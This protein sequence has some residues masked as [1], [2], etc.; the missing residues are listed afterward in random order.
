[1]HFFNEDMAGREVLLYVNREVIEAIGREGGAGLQD[2]IK[3]VKAGPNYA[4]PGNVCEK[5]FGLFKM[6]RTVAK[7]YPLYIAYLVLFV[8]AATIDGGFD[9]KAYYPR[10]CKALGE[11]IATGSYPGFERMARLWENLERWSKEERAEELGRFT[12]R[13]RGGW[14]HVGIPLSQLILSEEER[15]HLP[16]VFYEAAIDPT[17]PPADLVLRN[18]LLDY[19]EKLLR[20]RTRKLLA[21]EGTDNSELLAALLDFVLEEL[22]NWDCTM[23]GNGSDITVTKGPTLAPKKTV[24]G[25]RICIDKIDTLLGTAECRLRIKTNRQIPEDGLFL[26]YEG[27][28]Y[29]CKE[30]NEPSW[31]TRL[32]ESGTD[33]SAP[34]EASRLDWING[35]TFEDHENNWAAKLSGKPVRLFMQRPLES[36]KGWIECNQLAY[37]SEFIVACHKDCVSK[38]EAWGETCGEL[39][40]MNVSGLPTAWTLLK[41]I[42][43]TES[44]P[45][46]DVLTLPKQFHLYLQGGVKTGRGNEYL[47]FAPPTI[48]ITGGAGEEGVAVNGQVLDPAEAGVWRLPHE[49]HSNTTF[50]IQIFNRESKDVLERR[51][52]RLSEPSI[53]AELETSLALDKFGD[54]VPE[55]DTRDE[56][57]YVS[58]AVVYGTYQEEPYVMEEPL[59]FYLSHRIVFIGPQPGQVIDWPTQDPTVEWK[60]VWA[61]ASVGR[62]RWAVNYCGPEG[63]DAPPVTLNTLYKAKAFRRWKEAVWVNRRRNIKP[64]IKKLVSLWNVYVGVAKHV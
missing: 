9:D 41:G 10:L 11:Q 35:A 19:G 23:P 28:T 63:G 38:V 14:V 37:N 16:Q 61:L 57:S 43:A 1:V 5:A 13:R 6:P 25:M 49:G 22:T 2:F 48:V 7:E 21:A 15:E 52:I 4:W 20:R 34:C 31:T 32:W 50:E 47:H 36:I 42:D 33:S 30:A 24:V 18:I 56:A 60:P 62:N 17:D 29:I 55:G 8:Y 45:G 46:V 58:G 39:K 40:R 44:C 53:S 3:A 54:V 27:I 12:F 64:R 51:F 26:D 59:P